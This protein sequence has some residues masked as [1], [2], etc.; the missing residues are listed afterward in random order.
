MYESILPKV[1]GVLLLLPSSVNSE[2]SVW[3]KSNTTI[4]LTICPQFFIISEVKEDLDILT[5]T[6]RTP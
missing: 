3:F 1:P 4:D 6:I 5:P 2:H